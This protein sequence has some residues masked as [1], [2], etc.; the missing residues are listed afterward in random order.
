MNKYVKM[1][2]YITVNAKNMTTEIAKGLKRL[3]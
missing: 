2:Q 1:Y 3:G